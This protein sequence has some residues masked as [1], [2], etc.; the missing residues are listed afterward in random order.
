MSFNFTLN[1]E[2]SDYKDSGRDLGKY[3]V[4]KYENVLGNLKKNNI[5]RI[6]NIV[7]KDIQSFARRHKWNSLVP[8]VQSQIISDNES[9]VF[10]SEDK[11][12][13]FG[14]LHY[15]TKA[16]F[17]APKTA[18]ALH[19]TRGGKGYFSK[20]HMVSGIIAYDFFK[21][22]REALFNVQQYISNIKRLGINA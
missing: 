11:K 19:W 21:L 8:A 16:H 1:I 12:K 22:N 4:R 3:F 15:G 7:V 14:Y 6:T 10:P 18:Q 13:I 5:Q 9:I 20:G 2:S 17:V